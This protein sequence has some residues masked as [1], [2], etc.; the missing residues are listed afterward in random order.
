M[1]LRA[2]ALCK[3]RNTKGDDDTMGQS[4]VF[5]IQIQ[6]SLGSAY[7]DSGKEC[8]GS[9]NH[10]DGEGTGRRTCVAR[11]NMFVDL[12]HRRSKDPKSAKHLFKEETKRYIYN[13]IMDPTLIYI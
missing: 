13:A 2:E 1:L 8:Y 11:V 5:M 12:L 6:Y 3:K 4:D 9:R 7:V 10:V